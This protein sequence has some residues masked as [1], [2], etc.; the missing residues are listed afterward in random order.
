MN[1]IHCEPGGKRFWQ[2][3]QIR[4]GPDVCYQAVEV[5][6]IGRGILPVKRGLQNRD[7]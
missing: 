4:R 6:S 2:H 7:G 3:D 5:C 1:G